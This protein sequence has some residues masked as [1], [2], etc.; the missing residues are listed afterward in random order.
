MEGLAREPGSFRDPGGHVYY[1]RGKVFR[2]VTSDAAGDFEWV[3]ATG[4]LEELAGRG[5]LIAGTLA[6]E[7]VLPDVRPR[8]SFVVEHPRIPF[9]SYPYEWCFYA[10]RAA[11]VHQLEVCLAALKRDV[12]VSDASAYNVQ[13]INSSPVFIDYLSFRPY[14]KGK[15]WKAHQQYC[16]QFLNPLLLRSLLGVPHNAWYRGTLEGIPTAELNRLIPA[17]RKLSWNV[18]AHVVLQSGLHGAANR[19][20]SNRKRAAK[21]SFDK[22]G[23]VSILESLKRYVSKLGPRPVANSAWHGYAGNHSYSEEEERAKRLFVVDFLR[24]V[25]P[26]VV[27]DLGCNVGDYS[28]LALDNGATLA[29]GLDTDHPSLEKAWLRAR[30]EQINFLPLYLDV[31][32]PSPSQ[33]WNGTE[34]KSLKER[35]DADA[36]FSLALL[37]HLVFGKNIPLDSA[38]ARLVELAPNGVVE[39]VPKTDPMV[40]D[41][42]LL[43]K[44]I[45]PG[46][47]RS[48]FESCLQCRARI[49][50]GKRVSE[51]GRRLY[52]YA[53]N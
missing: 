49:V 22:R 47:T 14:E 46:Y 34:R 53:E 38:V 18:F 17:A 11:A 27:L 50:T 48:A 3:R 20:K 45:F 1:S 8:P 40:R 9:V 29:V 13:F 39:F 15:A 12:M 43:R 10:L 32:N 6:D 42:L 5:W 19:R 24:E 35:V 25:K 51:S 44:D 36:V 26:G 4:L 28:V 2:T 37:H 23:M 33:G 41:M 16:A 7:N 21:I 31:S 52:W 30:R